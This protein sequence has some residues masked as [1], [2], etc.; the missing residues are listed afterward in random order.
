[1]TWPNIFAIGFG[2]ILIIFAFVA[3]WRGLSVKAHE[4]EDQ[5]KPTLGITTLR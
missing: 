5:A 4:P 1:M 3:V 2:S